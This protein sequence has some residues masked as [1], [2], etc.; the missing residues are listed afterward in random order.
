MSNGR[1]DDDRDRNIAES[2]GISGL[3]H[4]RAALHAAELHSL[5][6]Q[7]CRRQ[8]ARLVQDAEQNLAV[9]D[10]VLHVLRALAQFD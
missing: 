3:S 5:P 6:P 2:L 8:V 10:Y 4:T 9:R 1:E 7:E